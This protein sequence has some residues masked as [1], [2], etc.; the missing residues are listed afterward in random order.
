M[1]SFPFG[2]LLPERDDL[3]ATNAALQLPETE[4]AQERKLQAVGCKES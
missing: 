2:S 3:L 1:A 4:A